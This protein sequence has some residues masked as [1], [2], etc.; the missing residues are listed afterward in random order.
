MFR[1]TKP[2]LVLTYL[3]LEGA[4]QRVALGRLFWPKLDTDLDN[5]TTTLGR[6]KRAIPDHVSFNNI[7]ASF[8]IESDVQS[9]ERAFQLEDWETVTE[10]YQGSF[11][12]GV[13]L[14][15]CS[16]ELE[17]WVYRVREDLASKARIALLKMA[18]YQASLTQFE[19]AA[20]YALGVYPFPDAP[21]L[22]PAEFEW[23][24]KLLRAGNHPKKLSEK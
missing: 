6:L 22:E 21:E 12:Q 19:K 1:R 13:I 10:L 14:D 18:Q 24:Y 9:L 17:E 15:D 5:L 2:L 4:K 3:S 20:H 11:L 8:T 23:L 16:P 7:Y